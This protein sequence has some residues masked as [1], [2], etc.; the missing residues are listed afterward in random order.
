MFNIPIFFSLVFCGFKSVKTEKGKQ[1]FS[2][3]FANDAKYYFN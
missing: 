1:T 3:T 2:F